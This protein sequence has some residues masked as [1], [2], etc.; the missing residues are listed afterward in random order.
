L[1]NALSVFFSE[2]YEDEV[3]F[4]DLN[5]AA[6][7]I[8]SDGGALL[9]M[10]SVDIR[11]AGLRRRLASA[12]TLL[13]KLAPKKATCLLFALHSCAQ[14]RLHAEASASGA[15]AE[16]SSKNLTCYT[17]DAVRDAGDRILSFAVLNSS[18]ALRRPDA[19]AACAARTPN[20][21]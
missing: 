13:A 12:E 2:K 9:A 7:S 6:L 1:A 3:G 14:Q 20:G 4:G 16:T 21:T 18:S 15:C 5:T 10:A 17:T 19:A 8:Y 11:V